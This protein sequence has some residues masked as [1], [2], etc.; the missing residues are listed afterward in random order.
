MQRFR[1]TR[2]ALA[3]AILVL[4]LGAG[5]IAPASST[6]RQ[7]ADADALVSLYF[8][9]DGQLG[10]AIRPTAQL[11][12]DISVYDATLLELFRGPRDD[13]HAAGLRTAITDLTTLAAPVAVDAASGVATV[14]LTTAFVQDRAGREADDV[15]WRM[16]QV[17][18]TL[19]QFPEITA[20]AFTVDG[21]PLPGT[22]ATGELTDAPLTRLDIEELTPAI[23]LERPGVWQQV[24]SPLHLTGTANVFEA[25]VSW[26]LVDRDGVDIGS[27]WFMAT[28]GTGTRGTFD[29]MLEVDAA[30]GRATLVLYEASA[31][32]GAPIHVVSVPIEF[33]A[34]PAADGT[35]TI[36]PS[37]PAATATAAPP[38]AT[39]VPP[40]ATA[41]PAAGDATLTLRLYVCPAGVDDLTASPET[42]DRIIIRNSL[43]FTLTVADDED[44]T[45]FADFED[46]DRRI[47]PKLKDQVYV[48]ENVPFADY[49]LEVARFPDDTDA[50]WI[51]DSYNVAGSTEDGY[52]LTLDDTA[53]EVALD[54]YFI[55]APPI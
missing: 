24:G 23:L 55:I 38:T 51:A 49:D 31:M 1:V 28:S 30:P 4:G 39:R 33:V 6:A 22:T 21:T 14:D 11:A 47:D 10:V 12:Q 37:T 43:D 20:V 9:R 41:T 36:A 40:T 46:F 45:A 13:E 34:A 52:T 19:T 42:C 25:V 15:P 26:R 54:I 8:L 53:T 44:A 7:T 50:V 18:A 2:R 17:I 27:G 32:D 29:E 35:P 5:I 16:A 48:L 3:L